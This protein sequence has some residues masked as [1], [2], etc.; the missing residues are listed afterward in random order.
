MD[1]SNTTQKSP[2]QTVQTPMSVILS[3]LHSQSVAA[4]QF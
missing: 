2:D 4:V 3:G 1:N